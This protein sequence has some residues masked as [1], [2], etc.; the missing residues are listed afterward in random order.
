MVSTL[1]VALFTI[2]LLLPFANLIRSS[3]NKLL[4]KRVKREKPKKQQRI[5]LQ[6]KPKTSEPEETIFI[7]IND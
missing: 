5:K 2:K 7:G 1:L 4:S 3:F 6:Q